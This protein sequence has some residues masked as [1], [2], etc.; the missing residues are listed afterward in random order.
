MLLVIRTTIPQRL[1][2][3]STKRPTQGKLMA[4]PRRP[5]KKGRVGNSTKAIEKWKT[6]TKSLSHITPTTSNTKPR[7]MFG[8]NQE[9]CWFAKPVM[10]SLQPQNLWNNI[11]A[12]MVNAFSLFR[13]FSCGTV[14]WSASGP[15]GGAFGISW[16]CLLAGW[17]DMWINKRLINFSQQTQ[18]DFLS[19]KVPGRKR[20]TSDWN[21]N[22]LISHTHIASTGFDVWVSRL[23][24]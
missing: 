4:S 6:V 19:A 15:L 17:L 16:L 14:L 18:Q 9:W 5:L 12:S 1:S 13:F 21:F 11:S 8:G 20:Q 24:F 22:R 7:M 3:K 2:W 10:E 23:T